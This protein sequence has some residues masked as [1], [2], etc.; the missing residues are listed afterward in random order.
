[1]HLLNYPVPLSSKSVL[2]APFNLTD[3][4]YFLYFICFNRTLHVYKMETLYST[5]LHLGSPAASGAFRLQTACF[6]DRFWP[7]TET[8]SKFSNSSSQVQ[9]SQPLHRSLRTDLLWK[10]L[11]I[12]SNVLLWQYVQRYQAINPAPEYHL[13]F[14]WSALWAMTPVSIFH[15][16]M[17]KLICLYVKFIHTDEILLFRWDTLLHCGRLPQIK[18]NSEILIFLRYRKFFLIH[19]VKSSNQPTLMPPGSPASAF[20]STLHRRDHE[21]FSLS[22]S[23]RVLHVQPSLSQSSHFFL[24]PFLFHGWI[25]PFFANSNDF[26]RERSV[27]HRICNPVLSIL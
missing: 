11:P 3:S 10:S 21:E 4:K 7:D 12:D 18:N 24:R 13:L 22:E 5:I 2:C 16:K 27:F 19:I 6:Y 14:G 9:M 17:K 26:L 8:P 20:S 1:M 15:S 23:R 25:I